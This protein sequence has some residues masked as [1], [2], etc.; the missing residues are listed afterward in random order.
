MLS[1]PSY[2]SCL[3]SSRVRKICCD[4]FSR[5]RRMAVTMRRNW[6]D[7]DFALRHRDSWWSRDDW[8]NDWKDWPSD[9]P[10]PRD[11]M[12][13]VSI[14]RWWAKADHVLPSYLVG[15]P[16]RKCG[17]VGAVKP[18]LPSYLPPCITL[19]SLPPA[20]SDPDAH[21]NF[22]STHIAISSTAANGRFYANVVLSW[23]SR[24][25]RVLSRSITREKAKVTT[26]TGA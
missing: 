26:S 19:P 12:S 4:F 18:T 10:R 16:D 5:H 21:H 22:V 25:I 20:C 11:L 23:N 6:Y 14:C 15:R 8:Y 2:T 3:L 7:D 1:P 17:D 24:S 9:W 13:R